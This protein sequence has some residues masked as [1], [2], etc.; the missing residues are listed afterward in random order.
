[1]MAVQSSPQGP[2]GGGCD[3]DW[4]DAEGVVEDVWIGVRDEVVVGAI[5]VSLFR[6]MAQ[7]SPVTS[8]ET[9]PVPLQSHSFE[10]IWE[11]SSARPNRLDRSA[12]SWGRVDARLAGRRQIERRTRMNEHI[13]EVARKACRNR[14]ALGNRLRC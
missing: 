1:M 4:V 14:M 3:A 6:P 12:A 2:E 5:V 13:L 7:P 8:Q 9:K 11:Q 10:V